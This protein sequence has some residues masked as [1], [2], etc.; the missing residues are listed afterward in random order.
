MGRQRRGVR[1][2]WSGLNLD[3]QT[4]I[5]RALLDHAVIKP[6]VSGARSLDPARVEPVWKL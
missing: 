1:L 5:V 4:A 2:A 3:R 6:G